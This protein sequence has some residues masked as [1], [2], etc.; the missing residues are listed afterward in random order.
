MKLKKS[1]QVIIQIQ[2]YKKIDLLPMFSPSL[3]EAPKEYSN[4]LDRWR[5]QKHLTFL[6]TLAWRVPSIPATVAPS[7]RVISTAGHKI[8][9]LRASLSECIC[10]HIST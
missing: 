1:Q 5:K 9:K 3:N 4:P 6:A 7:E 8:T 2:E 10:S